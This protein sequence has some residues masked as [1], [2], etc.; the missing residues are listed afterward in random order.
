MTARGFLI[1]LLLSLV[2]SAKR[3]EAQRFATNGTYRQPAGASPTAAML[4]DVGIDQHLNASLPLNATFRD[5]E[6]RTVHLSDYFGKRPVVLALDYYRCPMLCTQV[7]N[8][9]LKVSHALPQEIG[10][11]FDVVA[12]S[13]DPLEKAE[14]AADKK[15]QYVRAYRR[16][17]AEKGWHFLTG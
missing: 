2:F 5:E 1:V 9:V 6:N 7:L 10:K 13:F 15:R 16:D 12:V 11:D 8:G 17:G 4:Q 14:L 3:A